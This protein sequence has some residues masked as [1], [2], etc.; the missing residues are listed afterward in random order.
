MGIR[1]L[2]WGKYIKFVN[3]LKK[4]IAGYPYLRCLYFGDL[5][6]CGFSLTFQPFAMEPP[7]PLQPIDLNNPPIS[8]S[9]LF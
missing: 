5:T 6:L 8:A 7:W 2:T 4:G 3:L 1:Y 9:F